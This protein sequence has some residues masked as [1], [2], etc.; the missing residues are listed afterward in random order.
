M[1]SI[2]CVKPPE[3]LTSFKTF[4][5]KSYFSGDIK[6]QI[7]PLGSLKIVM[8]NKPPCKGHPV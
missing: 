7:Q 3:K 4:S 8:F 6:Y 2:I 5:V 1:I